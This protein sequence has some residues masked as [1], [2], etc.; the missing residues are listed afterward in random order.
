MTSPEIA[1]ERGPKDVVTTC[2][3]ESIEEIVRHNT[4]VGQYFFDRAA[5]RFFASRILSTV[6]GGRFFVTS[7]R[8]THEDGAWDGKRRYTVRECVDGRIETRSDHG[9]FAT[10]QEAK[11]AARELVALTELRTIVRSIQEDQVPLELV[12]GADAL[13]VH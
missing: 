8:D 6:Y 5:M 10:T 2:H 4:I 1:V 13:T 9:E 12:F 3:H 11:N 7:E